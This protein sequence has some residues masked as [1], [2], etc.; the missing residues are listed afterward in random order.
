MGGFYLPGL[1]IGGLLRMTIGGTYLRGAGAYIW[2]ESLLWEFY[3]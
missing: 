3:A 2:G 1:I